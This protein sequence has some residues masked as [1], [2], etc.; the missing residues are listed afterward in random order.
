VRRNSLQLDSQ[1]RFVNSAPTVRA[2][3]GKPTRNDALTLMSRWGPRTPHLWS[4]TRAGRPAN[5]PPRLFSLGLGSAR[6][7]LFL[8]FPETAS[9]TRIPGRDPRW[10]ERRRPLSLVRWGTYERCPT[11]QPLF[12]GMAGASLT[13]GGQR[14]LGFPQSP[15]LVLL[16]MMRSC[17]VE[18]KR[19]NRGTTGRR[20]AGFWPANC[21]IPQESGDCN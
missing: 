12:T 11:W 19:P 10:E 2:W 14:N 7:R 5:Q 8:T 6:A 21:T 13:E 4:A 18:V 15:R 9:A 16:D 17:R 1:V 20:A 3:C